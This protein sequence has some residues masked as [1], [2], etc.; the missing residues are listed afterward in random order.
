M[1][2]TEHIR[3]VVK[4]SLEV[5]S[6]ERAGVNGLLGPGFAG[7]IVDVEGRCVRLVSAEDVDGV[8]ELSEPRE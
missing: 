7:D 2:L 8:E 1:E 6:V 3:V 4:D 5:G